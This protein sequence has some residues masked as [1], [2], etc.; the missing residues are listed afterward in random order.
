MRKGVSAPAAPSSAALTPPAVGEFWKE[1]GGLYAGI[2]VTDDGR[3]CHLVLAKTERE[4]RL[5]WEA[6][7]VWATGLR[8]EGFDDWS[9]MNR[10]DG[11]TL[12]KN[13]KGEF[14][15]NWHWTSEQRAQDSDSAWIQYFDYGDQYGSHEFYEYRARAVRRLEI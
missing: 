3:A 10:H 14:S 6:A 2:S 12:F 8:T 9:L 11:L 7:K 4:H 13:L 5:S 1:Q 15:E